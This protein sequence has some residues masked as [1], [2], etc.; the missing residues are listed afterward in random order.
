M[1]VNTKMKKAVDGLT[2]IPK[3][4]EIYSYLVFSIH[5]YKNGSI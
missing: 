1:K 5:E 4:R 3:T 2:D